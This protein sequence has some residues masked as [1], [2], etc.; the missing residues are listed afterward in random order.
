VRPL[1]GRAAAGEA[2]SSPGAR[3]ILV[4]GY[5][6]P[7]R[8]D[9]GLGPAAAAEIERLGRPGVVVH[10]NYQLV[11]EDAADVA[12]ADVVWFID[13]TRAGPEPF[14]IRRVTPAENSAFTSHLA[15]PETILAIAERYY[16][17]VPE[18]WL[19]GIR[20][21]AF[22][23]FIERLTE[24]ATDNLRHA[25][26]LISRIIGGPGEML[27]EHWPWPEAQDDPAH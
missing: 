11:L 4:I 19:L 8:G 17:K 20:G 24:R 21:Y 26:N 16:N 13:A 9:D 25:V 12:E 27:H 10:D 18:A 23:N 2:T 15:D 22:D 7:G 5:G 1:D 14:G 3:R 6:N